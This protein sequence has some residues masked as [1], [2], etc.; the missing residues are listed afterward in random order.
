[1]SEA[2][3]V[4]YLTWMLVME[5]TVAVMVQVQGAGMSVQQL[6]SRL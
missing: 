6:P 5:V 3:T 1:M 2:R 4:G